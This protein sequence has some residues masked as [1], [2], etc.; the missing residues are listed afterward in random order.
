MDYKT[1]HPVARR[2]EP[3]HTETEVESG[4]WHTGVI[5]SCEICKTPT[6]YRALYGETPGVGICSEECNFALQLA[7]SLP[8]V[9]EEEPSLPSSLEERSVDIREVEGSEPSVG[10]IEKAL[11]TEVRYKGAEMPMTVAED[12]ARHD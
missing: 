10:T 8:S 11:A 7:G 3:P 5:T 12:F 1:K 2:F 9:V 4:V 6:A